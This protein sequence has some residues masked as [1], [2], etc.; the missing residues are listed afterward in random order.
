M[1][2]LLRVAITLITTLLAG[3]GVGEL[4]DKFGAKEKIPGY[5]NPYKEPGAGIDFKKLGLI[6]LLSVVGVFI[7]KKLQTM[8]KFKILFATVALIIATLLLGNI[9]PANGVTYAVLI[10]TAAGGVGTPFLFRLDYIPQW[11]YWND[12]GNAINQLVIESIEDGV[13]IDATDACIAAMRG[14]Q[15]VG[16]IAANDQ[17]MPCASGRI[18]NKTVQVRGTTSAAGAINFYANSDNL[19]GVPYKIKSMTALANTPT[20][21]T[22]FAALFLPNLLAGTDRVEVLY[23]DSQFETYDPAELNA[24]SVQYQDA[25][26]VILNNI[27]AAIKRATITDVAGGLFYMLSYDIKIGA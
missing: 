6:A 26:G 3:V 17:L 4:A 16:A 1:G 24:L 19:D 21:V 10:G 25:P 18:R 14:Y 5:V 20:T 9:L 15:Q 11:I 12:A 22:N 23:Q 13:Y 8:F 7:V 27:N 2:A